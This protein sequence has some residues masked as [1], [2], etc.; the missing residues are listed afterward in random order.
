MKQAA[1]GTLLFLIVILI[2]SAMPATMWDHSS[3]NCPNGSRSPAWT[4]SSLY[5]IGEDGTR[6]ALI[7]TMGVGCNGRAWNTCNVQGNNGD[8]YGSGWGP[9]RPYYDAAHGDSIRNASGDDADHITELLVSQ[10]EIRVRSDRAAYYRAYSLTT[11]VAV[12]DDPTP[13][14]PAEQAVISLGRLPAGPYIVIGYDP[15]TAISVGYR[16]FMQ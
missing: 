1:I 10:G 11:G 7:C 15:A 9:V 5:E 16:T 6:G 4:Q 2:A 3:G 12:Y 8:P 13:L 14:P